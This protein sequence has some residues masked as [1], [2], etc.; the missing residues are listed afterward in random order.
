MQKLLHRTI[1]KV[2]RDLETMSFNTAISA[3]MILLNDL[4]P[5]NPRP[6]AVVETFVLLLSPFAPHLAEELW[7]R[8]G[9]ADSLAY[10]PW[11]S[12]DPAMLVDDTVELPVCING[13]VKER[14]EVPQ[15]AD[16]AV[17]EAVVRGHE[18]VIKLLGDKPIKK[19]VYVPGKMV[20]LVV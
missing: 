20:N 18:R 9:H 4:S 7:S 1:A 6:K 11:P 19:V 8:L 14:I 17:V 2:T 3:M 15:G 16:A 12:F 5:R 13:K 10:A